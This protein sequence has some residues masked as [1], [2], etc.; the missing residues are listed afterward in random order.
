M[1]TFD[2]TNEINIAKEKWTIMNFVCHS[3]ICFKCEEVNG[4]KIERCTQNRDT[5]RKYRPSW[6]PAQ[7]PC[8][9]IAFLLFFEVLL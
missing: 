7:L 3:C 8:E 2:D 9:R 6:L 4:A 1:R 5:H